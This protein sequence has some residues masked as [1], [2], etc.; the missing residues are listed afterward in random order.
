MLCFSLCLT[1]C[2]VP[3]LAAN[4]PTNFDYDL[5]FTDYQITYG[6]NNQ[7]PQTYGTTVPLSDL[8]TSGSITSTIA[9]G[10]KAYHLDI[11]PTDDIY[12]WFV[13][14]SSYGFHLIVNFEESADFTFTPYDNGTSVITR[15]YRPVCGLLASTS[16]QLLGLPN[17]TFYI[18]DDSDRLLLSDITRYNGATILNPD[19]ANGFTAS[20]FKPVSG[21]SERLIFGW[22]RQGEAARYPSAGFQKGGLQWAFSIGGSLVYNTTIDYLEIIAGNTS[23]IISNQEDIINIMDSMQGTLSDIK[24]TV[25]D[26]SNQLQD[27]S[28]NIWQAAGETI[29]N[30]IESLFVPSTEDI[31]EVKQGFD[32][33]AKDKLGGAYT[34][35]ETVEDTITQV[36]DKLNNPSAAEG[37]EFPGI[38]V[39]LGGEVGTVVLAE[40]QIVT[41]P[42]ELTAILHPLGGTIISIIAGLGTFNVLKDM[43]ECFLSGFSYAEYLHRNKG[44]SDE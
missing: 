24:D 35:M 10:R 2:A 40:K 8:L 23:T 13:N 9:E 20:D 12:G 36:N 31:S 32:D 34:A 38:A 14:G 26:T 17:D 4:Y 33:L 11:N 27:S 5:V 7:D 28:S 39:P 43:V 3:A 29:S 44:G 19:S 37:V 22:Q 41:L 42:M 1:V 6:V 18:Y 16:D 25:Q 15:W 30:A 21:N